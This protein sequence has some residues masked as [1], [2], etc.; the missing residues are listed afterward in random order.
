MKVKV[1]RKNVDDI[2]LVKAISSYISQEH[3]GNAVIEW[4]QKND[5]HKHGETIPERYIR[6]ITQK[7]NT[8]FRRI[9][10]VLYRNIDAWVK[11][12][13]RGKRSLLK[14]IEKSPLLTNE[15]I[16][17]LRMLIETTFKRA[18]GIKVKLPKDI[19]RKW[20]QAKLQ[21]PDGDLERW[22]TQSY[23]AGRLADVLDNS[24]TYDEMIKLARKMPLTR[25]DELIVEAAKNNAARYIVG[26]GRKLA[27][28]AEDVALQQHQSAVN[29]LVQ[30]YFTGELKHTKYNGEGF[31][32]AE[33]E[34]L[35]ETDSPV[36]NI[37]ELATELKNRFKNEDAGRDWNRV[38]ESE[39]RYATNLGRL[40]EIQLEG[41]GN[42]DEILVYYHVQPTACQ[43]CKKLYLEK[44]GITPKLFKLSE[45]MDN[46]Q[47]TGGMNVGRKA[48]QIGERNGWL[49]NAI[50]HANC[51]CY[52]ILY[53][54]GY[55]MIIPK[56]EQNYD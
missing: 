20:S 22:I 9:I 55:S 37:R 2:E 21:L 35:L 29:Y 48:G 15:Q 50:A 10:S 45:I 5:K 43:Y 18:I 14:P 49:P 34:A 19:E 38:A 27:N 46:V 32:H 39:I 40:N 47:K 13:T 30:K 23:V 24:S 26:Y 3:I 1:T 16:E 4:L 33:V 7:L 52:P 36:K 54:E 6:V 31:S 41:G 25:Q 42:P 44:D 17:E 8:G 12:S 28:I 56:G 51:H 53:K 11:F